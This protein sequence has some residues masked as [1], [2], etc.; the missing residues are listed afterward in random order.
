MSSNPFTALFPIGWSLPLSVQLT[1][2]SVLDEWRSLVPP[3]FANFVESVSFRNGE[4]GAAKRGWLPPAICLF[5]LFAKL[6]RALLHLLVRQRSSRDVGPGAHL[7]A[8]SSSARC[9]MHR[10]PAGTMSDQSKLGDSHCP[11]CSIFS[12]F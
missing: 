12:Y 10:T 4:P 8:V 5:R 2:L 1:G 6:R 9:V 3:R 7:P 11:P